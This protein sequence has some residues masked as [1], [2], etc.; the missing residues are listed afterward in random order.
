MGTKNI[1]I[2]LIIII[3]IGG[4]AWLAL[5]PTSDVPPVDNGVTP[6]D[7]IDDVPDTEE[8]SRILGRVQ[9]IGSLRYDV[10]SDTPDGLITGQFW[11]KD[12]KIRMEMEVEGQE[13]VSLIDIEEEVAY[14]YLPDFEIATQMSLAQAE[15]VREV[16][17]KDQAQW[18]LDY[19]PTIVG[20]ETFGDYDCLVV[21]YVAQGQ[22]TTVWIWEE[23]GLPV[24]MLTETLDGTVDAQIS[25]IEFVDISDDFFQLPS[26]VEVTE[27]PVF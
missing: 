5:R 26:G 18:I 17:A 3:L 10:V 25:N 22:P 7:D 21:E 2:A 1:I 4:G 14:A 27:S 23:R 15:E 13:I 24:R 12:G 20:R 9:E 8:L 11:Q 19:S 6:P 16:S